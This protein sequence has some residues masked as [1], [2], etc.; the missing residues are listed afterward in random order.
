MTTDP[1][2][3]VLMQEVAEAA[4]A[5]A[6]TRL[7]LD[8]A[9]PLTVQRDMAFLREVRLLIQDP[10]TQKDLLHLRRWRK[11]IDNVQSRGILT[12][13]AILVTGVA[14]AVWIGVQDLMPR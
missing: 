8:P 4:V 3:K 13:V 1:E 5:K 10:E 9:D 14:A 7:G 2:I 12:F 11:T 6:F